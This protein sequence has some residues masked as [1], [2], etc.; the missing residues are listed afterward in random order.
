MY[1]SLASARSFSVPAATATAPATTTAATATSATTTAS[2]ASSSAPSSPAATTSAPT[3]ADGGLSGC[4]VNR[5][6]HI[7]FLVLVWSVCA[8][9]VVVVRLVPLVAASLSSF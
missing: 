6:L 1:A 7:G 8:G 3:A 4:R 9:H 2:T 5:Q